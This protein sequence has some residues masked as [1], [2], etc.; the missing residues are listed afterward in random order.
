MKGESVISLHLQIRVLEVREGSFKYFKR[1]YNPKKLRKFF[2]PN[3]KSKSVRILS[4]T[5]LESKHKE[6]LGF[7]NGVDTLHQSEELAS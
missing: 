3:K 6:G 7:R 1:I 5:S 4:R 2:L